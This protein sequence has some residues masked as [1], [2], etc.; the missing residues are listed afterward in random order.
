MDHRILVP[1]DFTDVTINSLKYAIDAA[2]IIGT[3]INLLHIV[4]TEAE[5]I[6]ASEKLNEVIYNHEGSGVSL[7]AICKVGDIYTDIGSTAEEL[8]S[9]AIFMGTHGMTGLQ[10]IFG[11][12]ALKVITNSGVPFII[13]QDKIRQDD[14]IDD[15]V[16]PVDMGK[17][18]KQILT[19][20]IRSAHLFKAK[21]HLF[22]NKRQDE[23]HENSVARNLA[24]S[25]KY[26]QDHDVNFTVSHTNG[27]DTFDKELVRF[28]QDLGADMI[29]IVNHKE[30]ALANLL[31]SN[32]D[33]KVITNEAKV[34]VLIV[35]AKDLT[36]VN[37]IFQV[38]S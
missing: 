30:D 10:K 33:Q 15:I 28:S 23:F 18:D 36:K 7:K 16:V 5:K 17:E 35:N 32:F 11:S 14:R 34:P 13:T 26:L 21:V 3:G 1:I 12:R 20:V 24:F 2:K 19:T 22:V 4:S 37:D 38:F 8:G 25:K 27:M 6:Q 31:G 29:A 9:G